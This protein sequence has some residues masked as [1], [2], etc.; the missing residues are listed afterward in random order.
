M[1]NVEVTRAELEAFQERL[2]SEQLATLNEVTRYLAKLTL[3][4]VLAAGVFIAA[5]F[6]I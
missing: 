4:L 1:R 6:L 3:T 2:A 5:L